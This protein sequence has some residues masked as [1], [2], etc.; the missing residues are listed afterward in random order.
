MTGSDDNGARSRRGRQLAF[1]IAGTA[2]AY[3]GVQLIGAMNGW[4][5]RTMGFF[6][7][8]ALA[9]FGWALV[10]AFMIWRSG[11]NDS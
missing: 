8:A 4:T 5:T 7:L 3:V 11:Q 6:D 10:S 2:V 1:I 9:V